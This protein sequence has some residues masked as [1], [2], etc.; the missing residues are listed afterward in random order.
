MALKLQHFA[1]PVRQ[2]RALARPP[3]H[4]GHLHRPAAPDWVRVR[5]RVWFRVRVRVWVKV[6]VRVW[7]RVW[8]R[9][10]TGPG[11]GRSRL[12]LRREARRSQA[13]AGGRPAAN[14]IQVL[15]RNREGPKTRLEGKLVAEP[16]LIRSRQS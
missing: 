15:L 16:A 5:V 10:R 6:R 4:L 7:V 1:P 8:V 12:K 11:A 3:G 2:T 14:K 9:L 13:S